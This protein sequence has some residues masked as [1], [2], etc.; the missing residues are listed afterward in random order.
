MQSQLIFSCSSATVEEAIAAVVC[1]DAND[2]CDD[3]LDRGQAGSK[4]NSFRMRLVL[5]TPSF[6]KP[7]LS[8]SSRLHALHKLMLDMY[9]QRSHVPCTGS[10]AS[11]RT[12]NFSPL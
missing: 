9:P 7:R 4:L 1:A 11:L 12:A 3:A 5:P 2:D 10:L 8:P 6:G